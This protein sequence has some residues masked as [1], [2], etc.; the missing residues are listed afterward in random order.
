MHVCLQVRQTEARRFRRYIDQLLAEVLQQEAEVQAA[1]MTGLPRLQQDEPADPNAF[2]QLPRNE[3]EQLAKQQESDNTRLENYINEVSAA[4]AP[5]PD[6]EATHLCRHTHTHTTPMYTHSHTLTHSFTHSLTRLLLHSHLRS[7][8]LNLL[9]DTLAVAA[10]YCG[11]QA[12]HPGGDGIHKQREHVMHGSAPLLLESSGPLSCLVLTLFAESC[13]T[14]LFCFLVV[15][16]L[17]LGF[18]SCAA[19]V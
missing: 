12:L 19:L 5:G 10:A 2:A 3:L 9:I 17:C 15:S 11:A 14:V 8:T 4:C 18:C 7:H 13:H 1:V 6:G 16:R